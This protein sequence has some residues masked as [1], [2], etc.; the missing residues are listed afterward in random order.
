MARTRIGVGSRVRPGTRSRRR[1]RSSSA[2]G[3]APADAAARA[4]QAVSL[5]PDRLRIWIAGHLVF[6]GSAGGPVQFDR[7]A[8]RAAMD[9]PELLIGSTSGSATAPAKPSAATSLEEY[10]IEN[11]EYTT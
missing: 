7:A 3:L 6:D 4:S 1:R 2:A 8:A 5:D 11:T 9:A 10:V